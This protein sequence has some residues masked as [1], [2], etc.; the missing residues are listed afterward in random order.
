MDRMNDCRAGLKEVADV[1]VVGILAAVMITL[2]SRV[3][4]IAKEPGTIAGPVVRSSGI[5]TVPSRDGQIFQYVIRFSKAHE[6]VE[7]ASVRE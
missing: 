1:I 4:V 7:A 3:P 5:E 6:N 2:F